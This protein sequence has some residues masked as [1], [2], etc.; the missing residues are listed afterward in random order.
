NVLFTAHNEMNFYTWGD[1][2]CCLPRG[3]TRAVLR[4]NS[5]N[6]LRLCAGD[7][8]IFKEKLGPKTG[9]EADA[10][11]T[12]RHAVRLTRVHPE[13]QRIM[14]EGLEINRT[15]APLIIDPL[16]GQP[17]VEIEWASADALPFAL[18]ISS[19]TDEEH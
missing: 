19:R 10:D 7:V 5:S 11:R 9:Q 16:N 1:R 3:S 12:R 4:D 17:Y 8:L 18:C 13:A 15:A 14:Q 2:E 6:R